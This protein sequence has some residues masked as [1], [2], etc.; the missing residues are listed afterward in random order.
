MENEGTEIEYCCDMIFDFSEYLDHQLNTDCRLILLNDE[1]TQYK[2]HKI[3]LASTSGFFHDAFNSEMEEEKTSEVEIKCNPLNLFPMVL[4]FLYSSLIDIKDDNIMAFYEIAYFYR[5]EIL[6]EKINEILSSKSAEQIMEY[7]E[8]C[9]KNELKQGLDLLIPYMA[10]HYG[11][12]GVHKF[13]DNLDT[14]T[15]CKVLT[16]ALESGTFSRDVKNEIDTF[17]N[18]EEPSKEEY[19]EINFVINNYYSIS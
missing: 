1:H 5:I 19:R 7:T 10:N 14:K 9:Y 8:F 11:N 12:I 15:Y 4:H 3:I 13:S 2:C 16:T 17:L 6:E 18:G